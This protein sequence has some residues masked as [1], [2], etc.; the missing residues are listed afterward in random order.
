MNRI[1]L[2]RHGNTDLLRE[3]LCGRTPGI[4]LNEEGR[5]QARE[6]SQTLLGRYKFSAVYSSP[7]ERAV[8]TAAFIAGPLGLRVIHDH[9][10]NEIDFGSWTGMRFADLH[11]LQAWR[12][13]NRNRSLS[14]APDGE[15]LPEVQARAWKSLREIA[16]N[17]G[18]EAVAVVSH[19]DV[20]RAL[21]ILL[22]GMPLDHILRFEISPASFTEISFGLDGPLIHAVNSQCY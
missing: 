4:S 2:I 18:G 20:I 14:S 17:H 16:R 22:L 7:L 3:F 13:Y 1:L 15:M 10:L 12:D 9:G 6:L 21:L 5:A 8:E 19:G 11:G